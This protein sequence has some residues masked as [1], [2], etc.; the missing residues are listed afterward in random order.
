MGLLSVCPKTK[1]DGQAMPGGDTEDPSSP[2]TPSPPSVYIPRSFLEPCTGAGVLIATD[3]PR[4]FQQLF[5][6]TPPPSHSLVVPVAYGFYHTGNKSPQI[7]LLKT[8]QM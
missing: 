2:L 7:Q 8:I 6:G 3:F 4:C 1:T 5:E